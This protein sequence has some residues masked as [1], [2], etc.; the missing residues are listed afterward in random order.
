MIIQVPTRLSDFRIDPVRNAKHSNYITEVAFWFKFIAMHM[1]F[2]LKVNLK[3][4]TYINCVNGR[5][6]CKKQSIVHNP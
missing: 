5:K 6:S 1:E 3:G 4:N 2:M